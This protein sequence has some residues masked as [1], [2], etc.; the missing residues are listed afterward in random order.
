MSHRSNVQREIE[1][2]T[3]SNQEHT[4]TQNRAQQSSDI[5]DRR[6]GVLNLIKAMKLR[7]NTSLVGIANELN[8]RGIP[9][10]RGG[11]WTAT[12][13]SRIL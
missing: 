2:D 10:L 7:G 13:V 8:K 6:A 3:G 12:Q 1:K 5:N 4:S 9:A 11:Q